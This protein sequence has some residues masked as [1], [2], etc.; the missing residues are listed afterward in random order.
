MYGMIVIDCN[1]HNLLFRDCQF[2]SNRQIVPE[3]FN[4]FF[5]F[6]MIRYK[7][8]QFRVLNLLQSQTQ[9][10]IKTQIYI[11]TKKICLTD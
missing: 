5:F 6:L 1:L 4:F 3:D 7:S 8:V 2:N 9:F 11:N 10:T